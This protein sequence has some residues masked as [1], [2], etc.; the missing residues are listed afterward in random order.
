MLNEKIN[1]M[2]SNSNKIENVDGT[3]VWECLRSVMH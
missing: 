1:L 3:F 2:L